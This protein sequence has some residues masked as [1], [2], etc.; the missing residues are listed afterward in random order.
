MTIFIVIPVYNRKDITRKCLDS[1]L[2]QSN[3]DFRIIVVDDASTDGTKEMIANE[4]PDVVLLHGNGDL[5]WTGAINEGIN[6]VL[7]NCTDEDYVLLLNDDLVVPE[8]YVSTYYELAVKFPETVIGSVILDI[9]D[10]ETILNGGIIVNWWHAKRKNLNYNE[11]IALFPIGYYT[12]VSILT[13]RGVLFPITVFQKV[14]LYNKEHYCHYGDTELPKRA[15]K[16]GYSLIVSYDAVVYS[17]PIRVISFSECDTYRLLDLKEYFF[18][19]RSNANLKTR[20]WF[21]YD[22]STN[23]FQGTV[24]FCCDFVRIFYHF[25]R[26]LSW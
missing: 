17:H 15:E 5:W 22:T 12:K 23:I 2:I 10:R 1:L 6:Y 20:F 19:I 7:E 9:N 16:F 8:N 21:A 4:F 26:R 3:T 24:F 14:G 13:G 25:L 11:K 18:G